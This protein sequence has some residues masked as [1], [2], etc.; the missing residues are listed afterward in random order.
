MHP[1]FDEKLGPVSELARYAYE[2]HYLAL[3]DLPRS[4]FF[5]TSRFVDYFIHRGII[6]EDNA[7]DLFD[8][9]GRVLACYEIDEKKLSLATAAVCN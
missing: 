5:N 1:H 2:V 9:V 4:Y 8:A 6:T 7:N 3:A